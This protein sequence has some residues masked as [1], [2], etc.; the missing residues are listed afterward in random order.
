[1]T[2][3]QYL[4]VYRRWIT[5]RSG[6][7]FSFTRRQWIFGG[8]YFFGLLGAAVALAAG[9]PLAA[10]APGSAVVAVSLSLGALDRRA[11]GAPIPLRLAWAQFVLRLLAPGILVWNFVLGSVDWRGRCYALVRGA[12]LAAAGRGRASARR[13]LGRRRRRARRTPGLRPAVRRLG[14]RRM[15]PEGAERFG[16]W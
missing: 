16:E 3:R 10:L 4:P 7:P 6:L 14:R 2:L 9:H 12:R 1:M 11:G 13:L 5:F 8:E 15:H